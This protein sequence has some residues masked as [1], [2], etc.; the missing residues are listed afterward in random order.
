MLEIFA[1]A[2]SHS[3]RREAREGGVMNIRPYAV[4]L[5]PQGFIKSYESRAGGLR[6][7]CFE[8]LFGNRMVEVQLWGDGKH[9]ASHFLK[10]RMSTIPT[11]FHPPAEMQEAIQQELTRKDHPPRHRHYGMLRAKP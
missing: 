1:Q 7:V 2:S 3:R 5:R 4:V 10:G 6:I 11:Y 9:R 8:H